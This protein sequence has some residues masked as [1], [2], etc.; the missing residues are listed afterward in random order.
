MAAI[1]G[2]D[3]S[4]LEALDAS[5][6][7]RFVAQRPRSIEL[8]AR[9]RGTMP[10]GVPMAW[11]D[12]LYEHPPM[13]IDRGTGAFF[14]DVDGHT[15][16]DMY[17][18][19]M[20][21]FCGHAPTPVVEAV[22]RRVA[23]GH[24]FLLPGEDAIAVAEHLAGRYG[25]PKWQFTLSAT[26]ANTEV[27]RLARQATGREIV[28]MFDGKYLGHGDATMVV[29]EDGALVPE[30]QGLPRWI[31]GQA[32]VIPFND[33]DG[34]RAALEPRDVALVLTEPAMTNIG[35]IQPVGGFHD[36]LREL[37]RATGTLLAIDETHTLVAAWGGLTSELGLDPDMLV[38]GKSIAAGVPLGA[39]GMTDEVASL[40][41]PPDEHWVVMGM[42]AQQVA[43]GGTLFANA[44]SMAAGRA[45][46][47]EVLTPEAF[48]RAGALGVRMAD[49][50][51]RAIAAAGLPWSVA[52][53]STHAYYSFAPTP[54]RNAAESR[55]ADD[56][57]LRALIRVFMAN[58]GVWES[59]WWL[60]PTVSLAHT[61][62]DVDRYVGVFEEFIAA[63]R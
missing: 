9:A 60:G 63:A 40:I 51:D 25:M 39:Y 4:R 10:R 29:L 55:E 5:E 8:I 20:S 22:S 61:E 34:L 58:R 56:P 48:D 7:E 46:L 43:T 57:D 62:E 45:A 32:R 33:V 15:Y 44:L 23:A 41:A 3:R 38:V 35:V 26:Q 47:E 54:A 2:L 24:Q 52:R 19:D 14:T 30:E 50:L 59:G 31:T 1:A 11:M 37:T 27:I 17:I 21:G 6:N 13:L 12:D 18:A 16:L 42:V 36:A 28:L 53:M 49:A